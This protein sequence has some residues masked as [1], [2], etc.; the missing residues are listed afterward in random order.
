MQES[1]QVALIGCGYMGR[2]HAA[3]IA[4]SND[5]DVVA[6]CDPVQGPLNAV[7]HYVTAEELLRNHHPDLA[8][9]SL[10]NFE[11][12]RQVRLLSDAG[13]SILCEKPLGRDLE[14]CRAIVAAA[15]EAGVRLFV[16][17]QRKYHTTLRRAITEIRELGPT[18]ANCLF[19]YYWPPAFGSP[20][21]RHDLARSGGI[22]IIDTGWHAL[23]YL[24]HTLGMPDEVYCQTT[25]LKEHPQIDSQAAVML[26][27]ASGAVIN[28]V[29][30]YVS[31]VQ[32][33][34]F[35]FFR[36]DR[37]VFVDTTQLLRYHGKD[38]ERMLSPEG[39]QPM[40]LMYRELSS[41]LRGEESFITDG[42]H[43]IRIMSLVHACYESA[44]SNELVKL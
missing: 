9:L 11:Y 2:E 3:A 37:S 34:E 30:N 20:T 26:R 38:A 41:A 1:I 14:S 17:A 29:F 44:R 7:P 33:F 21:W 12:E 15:E 28:L 4:R 24:E 22:A 36:E 25:S 18:F 8:V 40:D 39:E 16:S 32:S 43:A 6:T 35:H 23:D 31:P 42:T 5:F 10:P 13:V 27:Y 19:S